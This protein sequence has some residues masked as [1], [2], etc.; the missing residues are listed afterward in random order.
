M[1]ARE[2]TTDDIFLSSSIQGDVSKSWHKIWVQESAPRWGRYQNC[3][4]KHSEAHRYCRLPA[5]AL[6]VHWGSSTHH[7]KSLK[8]IRC[9]AQLNKTEIKSPLLSQHNLFTL[10]DSTIRWFLIFRHSPQALRVV[11]GLSPSFYTS[12]FT[13][14]AQTHLE[15]S[16]LLKTVSNVHRCGRQEHL[17]YFLQ[18]LQY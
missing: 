3:F 1:Q 2:R 12:I 13:F 4:R 7:I 16:L 9:L 10:T 11:K 5:P 8:P 18:D 15:T 14:I 17:P 6:N